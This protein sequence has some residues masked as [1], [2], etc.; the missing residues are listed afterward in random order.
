[1]KGKRN[2]LLTAVVL[3]LVTHRLPAPITE[4]P[5]SPTPALSAATEQ[6]SKPKA[7][8]LSHSFA[9]KWT[10][11]LRIETQDSYRGNNAKGEHR[12]SSEL[13]IFDISA[14][15]K[16]VSFHRAVW[17]GPPTRAAVIR[18]SEDTLTWVEKTTASASVPIDFYNANGRKAGPRRGRCTRSRTQPQAWCAKAIQRTFTPGSRTPA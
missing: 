8:R 12:V 13:W 9:G 1:M 14:D 4:I 18:T 15:Q 16:I 6:T 2:A 5:E 7:K 3:L 10:G 17:K 11:T